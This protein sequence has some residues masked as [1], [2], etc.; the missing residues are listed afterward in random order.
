[1]LK[2]F[3]SFFLCFAAA[4]TLT[5]SAAAN[6]EVYTAE[7][8]SE[9]A[10][11]PYYFSQLSEEAQKVYTELRSAV[12]N[13]KRKVRVDSGITQEDFNMIA[14]LLIL[15]DPLIFNVDDIM[16]TNVT[17]NSADFY[18]SYIFKKETYKKMVSAYE[19][20]ADSIL[21]KLTDDMTEY[22]KI[23]KIH[24]LIIKNSDYDLNSPTSGS[25]YGTLVKKKGKCDGYAKT[26]SYICGRAGIKTLTVLGSDLSKQSDTLH[27]WNKVLYRNKWYNV[28]VTYDDPL[29]NLR[30]NIRYDFFMVSDKDLEKSHL[31]SNGS[32]DVPAAK[33]SSK[34]Y[35][36]VYKKYAEDLDSAKSII[37]SELKSAA[38]NKK[39]NIS[40][41][42]SSE[43]LFDEVK[44]YIKSSSKI[45]TALKNAQ[46]GSD[47]ELAD[48]IY[49]S[50][51][52]DNQYVAKILIFYKD[53]D[54]D[55]FFTD[56]S[57]VDEYMLGVLED[58]GIE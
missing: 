2:K 36:K 7:A 47:N 11:M 30:E 56:L 33:D 20:R 21:A 8:A 13:S 18:I 35:F 24:D 28:D 57:M 5:V 15:H 42:C 22:E 29:S 34:D 25:I 58:Y 31:E 4:F 17:K 38:K 44:R 1:M 10:D 26:F 12:L 3:L 48:D 45:H 9:T 27:M 19:K 50:S 46:S 49:S 43:E 40:I 51:F 39:T 53:T 14:E 16:V 6:T 23:K 37:Q 55:Y 32:F 41:K 54:I 52:N